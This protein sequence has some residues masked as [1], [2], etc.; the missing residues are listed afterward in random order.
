M[1]S[2]HDP[3]EIHC[4]VINPDDNGGESLTL[5]TNFHLDRKYCEVTYD[6]EL[7]LQSYCNSATFTLSGALLTPAVLRKLADELEAEFRKMK[8]KC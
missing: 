4:F 8:N 7:T 1:T 3:D 5:T 6:Q 2:T